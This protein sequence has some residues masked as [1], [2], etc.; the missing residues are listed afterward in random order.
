M[1]A[2]SLKNAYLQFIG[3]QF[4][5]TLDD[6]GRIGTIYKGLIQYTLTKYSRALHLPHLTSHDCIRSLITRTLL[7]LK[8]QNSIHLESELQKIL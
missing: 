1:Q 6:P 7:L 2:F 8:T 5:N 3:T 4:R